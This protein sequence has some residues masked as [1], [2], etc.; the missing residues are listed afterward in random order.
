MTQQ[1]LADLLGIDRQYMWKIENGRMTSIEIPNTERDV[2]CELAL[3]AMGFT[4]P[5]Y[6]GMLEELRVELDERSNVKA[7]N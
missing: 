1:Q 5:Q 7:Q 4:N 6:A 3:L 2:P